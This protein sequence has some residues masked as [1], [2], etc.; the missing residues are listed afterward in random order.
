MKQWSKQF[1]QYVSN[2]FECF[3]GVVMPS[4]TRDLTVEALNTLRT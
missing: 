3:D 2:V 1:A 4:G